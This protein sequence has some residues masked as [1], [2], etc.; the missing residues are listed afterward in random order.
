MPAS[1]GGSAPSWLWP[2]T[3]TLILSMGIIIY[4]ST[5]AEK[6]QVYNALYEERTSNFSFSEYVDKH[7][8]ESA[9][10]NL[11]FQHLTL[12]LAEKIERSKRIAKE[13]GAVEK[14]WYNAPENLTALG[15]LV[16]YRIFAL[17][18]LMPLLLLFALPVLVDAL[19]Q[20]KK[21]MYRNSFTSPLRHNIG[22]R[23]IAV[24]MTY[25]SLFALFLPFA[26]PLHIYLFLLA[27]KLSGWW[28]WTAYLPKRI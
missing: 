5:G 8:W 6:E 1:S 23:V 13:D 28:L 4:V 3:I 26:I 14:I 22:G 9:K 15:L 18:T 20:R 11:M 17:I 2:F 7:A 24:P 27:F 10:S 21:A 25:L 16:D 12:H 19:M